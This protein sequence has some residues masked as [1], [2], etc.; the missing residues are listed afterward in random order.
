MLILPVAVFVFSCGCSSTGPT[1]DNY[2]TYVNQ[3]YHVNILY[4]DNWTVQ[5]GGVQKI[6]T[7]Y[8]PD[9]DPSN[10]TAA[11]FEVRL[12]YMGSSVGQSSLMDLYQFGIHESF[13]MAPLSGRKASISGPVNVKLGGLPALMMNYTDTVD[14][15]TV[16]G[17]IVY[18][19]KDSSWKAESGQNECITRYYVLEYSANAADFDKY[20]DDALRMIDSFRFT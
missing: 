20:L 5:E 15:K 11:S 6:V 17:L 2:S 16:N 9:S 3:S 13:A 1:A 19:L 10:P 4:P 18:T 14:N 7:F 12:D 8:P